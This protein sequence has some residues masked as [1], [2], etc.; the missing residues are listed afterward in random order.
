MRRSL[1][2]GPLMG[3]Q[4][5]AGKEEGIPNSLKR[6]NLYPQKLYIAVREMKWTLRKQLEKSLPT[7]I[8]GNGDPK[9]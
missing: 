3:A 6:H 8:L 7:S 5:R 1:G 4:F 9:H 2:Q